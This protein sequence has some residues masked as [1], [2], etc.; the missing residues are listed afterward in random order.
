MWPPFC[1][2]S[3]VERAHALFS[4]SM[5]T[6]QAQQN[7]PGMT[8]CLI[9]FAAL[10]SVRGIPAAG[11]RLLG[12]V[13]AIGG[14]DIASAWAATRME[15]KH[16]LA[17]IRGSL[18]ETEFQAEQT[19]GSKFSLEQ[20]VEYAQNLSLRTAEVSEKPDDLTAREYEV[21]ALIAQ[22]RSNA[23]IA[24]E[25]VVSKRTVEKHIANILSKLGFTAR[26]QIVRWAIENG[27]VKWGE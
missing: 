23:E 21:A 4:E 10:A 12:T 16:Y 3:E 19:A 17:L 27:P 15:Y 25:L 13:V 11:A 9:G 26:A 14:E 1:T 7:A 24:A 18:T 8:E 5:A 22:G 6:Q 2:I 20:A